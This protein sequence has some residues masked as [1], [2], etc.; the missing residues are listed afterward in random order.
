MTSSR[1]RR[2]QTL[3]VRS[4][5]E[6]W[7]LVARGL[8]VH[9]TADSPAGKVARDDIVLVPVTDMPPLPLGLIWRTAHVNARVRAL[10]AL[11]ARLSPRALPGG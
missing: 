1:T 4:T 6:I 5:N 7:A 11:A 3:L 8:I 9:F 10:A 2:R